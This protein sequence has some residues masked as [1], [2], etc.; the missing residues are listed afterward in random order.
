MTVS[1]RFKLINWS[2]CLLTKKYP[3]LS[4]SSF[5]DCNMK[6]HGPAAVPLTEFC[7]LLQI[8]SAN[9]WT[10]LLHCLRNSFIFSTWA[11]LR[12]KCATRACLG[13]RSCSGPHG[14]NMFP[15]WLLSLPLIFGIAGNLW[16]NHPVIW[17]PGV[18]QPLSRVH[19]TSLLL[20]F[21]FCRLLNSLCRW[22]P[23][24]LCMCLHYSL[25]SAVFLTSVLP[26][27]YSGLTLLAPLLP[28]FSLQCSYSLHQSCWE[29]KR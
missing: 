3:D 10:F 29:E 4:L 26:I 13:G 19:I 17:A 25:S 1:L 16:W 6:W 23:C 20:F 7:L 11:L 2:L 5:R 28:V 22:F 12:K 9:T 24:F 27:L 18:L 14:M 21:S 8:C 15:H